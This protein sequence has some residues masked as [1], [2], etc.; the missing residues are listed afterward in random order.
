MAAFAFDQIRELLSIPDHKLGVATRVGAKMLTADGLVFTGR[1]FVYSEKP[2]SVPVGRRSRDRRRA[3]SRAELKHDWLAERGRNLFGD[4]AVHQIDGAA[5]RRMDNQCNWPVG[6]ALSY[7]GGR[8]QA[9]EPSE[10][11]RT[12]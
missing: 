4:E 10:H 5:R 3:A 8:P 1:V 12:Q 6:I 2:D 9:C 7:R 11:G